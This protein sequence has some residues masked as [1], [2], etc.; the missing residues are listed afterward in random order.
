MAVSTDN[1]FSGPYLTNGVTTVFPFTFTAPSTAEVSVVLRDADSVD[2]PASGYTV[3]LVDGGGG[4]VVFAAPPPAGFSLFS[5]LTPAFT[6]DIAF[7][8]GSAW[9][10][11]PVNEGYDRSAARDQALKRDVDRGL[12]API[13]EAGFTLPAAE[14]RADKALFFAEDG[15]PDTISIDDFS[16]P[17]SEAASRS[18]AYAGVLSSINTGYWDPAINPPP[19]DADEGQTYFVATADGREILARNVGGTGVIVFERVTMASLATADGG[20]VGFSAAS[21]YPLGTVGKRLAQVITPQDQPFLAVGDGIADDTAALTAWIN[22]INSIADATPGPIGAF[23]PL[24]RFRYTAALPAITQSVTIFSDN[25][26]QGVLVPQGNF[27]CLTFKSSTSRVPDGG[28]ANIRIDGGGMTGGFALVVD[29]TQDFDATGLLISDAWNGI[30]C[31]QSGNPSFDGVLDK[32]RGT[33]GF[34]AVGYGGTIASVNRPL[35]NGQVD[36]IDALTLDLTI[37]GVYNPGDSSATLDACVLDGFVHT[38]RLLELRMLSC[39]TGLTTKNSAGLDQKYAPSFIRGSA[40]TENTYGLGLDLQAANDVVFDEPFTSSSGTKSG[41]SI[42]A[43]VRGVTLHSA[44]SR[45][46]AEHGWKIAAGATGVTFYDPLTVLNGASAAGIKDESTQGTRIIGGRCGG[47]D[48]AVSETQAN[49][50]NGTVA[51]RVFGADVTG[52]LTAGTNGLPFTRDSKGAPPNATNTLTVGA[53]PWT[54]TVGDT[55]ESFAV[56]NG[57]VSQIAVNGTPWFVT[58]GVGFTAPGGSQVVFT[59]SSAPTVRATK[60]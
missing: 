3:S 15:T 19:A 55:P 54:Y 40:E 31:R 8:N 29:W 37:T 9:R 41:G 46:N 4:S 21:T 43:A 30:S 13:G 58:G 10:A 60:V 35:R 52:N 23:L 45:S 11:E 36:K 18:E 49:G 27:D 59:Y 48:G 44:T 50:I 7:E 6:Q 16:A 25:A 53:S 14:A 17:A 1:A 47:G 22:A 38:V 57:T 20:G 24:G 51:T 2:T 26:R 34:Q 33:I 5:I 42:G 39:K 28:I 56:A 32:L 12:K